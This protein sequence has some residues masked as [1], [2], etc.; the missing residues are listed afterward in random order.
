M[1]N[2]SLTFKGFFPDNKTILHFYSTSK[3][4]FYRSR[5]FLKNL[6]NPF[7]LY[8]NCTLL[9]RWLATWHPVKRVWKMN[10]NEGLN[11]FLHLTSSEKW[12]REYL[13]IFRLGLSPA[14]WRW[15]PFFRQHCGNIGT[16]RLSRKSICSMNK[17]VKEE[18]FWPFCGHVWHF[19]CNISFISLIV[20]NNHHDWEALTRAIFS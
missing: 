15:T 6:Y 18:L 3:W 12:K 7:D 5:G 19:N 9:H 8:L 20:F 2:N 4:K 17:H 16:F 1:Q 13:F 11:M 10:N 14:L